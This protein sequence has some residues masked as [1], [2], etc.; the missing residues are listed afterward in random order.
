ML[1]NGVV[2]AKQ[3]AT[4]DQLGGGSRAGLN[5][6][7]GWNQPEYEAMGSL[8]DHEHDARY[9][10]A[11]EWCDVVL[12]AWEDPG[13]FNFKSEHFDLRGA[14]SEPKPH[15]NHVPILN[16]GSS[17]QGRAYAA[18]NSDFVFTIVPD[19]ETGSTSWSTSAK[20][21]FLGLRHAASVCR[22]EGPS[23]VLLSRGVLHACCRPRTE[24][25]T[26]LRNRFAS[27]GAPTVGA[28]LNA[29]LGTVDLVERL[30]EGFGGG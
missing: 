20:K 5:I 3:M 12:K 26:P 13:I 29:I 1:A 23:G 22:A 16:A 30:L 6:V 14:E 18:R 17:G 8:L 10:F 9:A 19:V 25:E 28:R 24:L 15:G 11:Q 7:A 4:L 21:S 2:T 27:H